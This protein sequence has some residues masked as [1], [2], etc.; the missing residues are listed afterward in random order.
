MPSSNA[1]LSTITR[2]MAWSQLADPS[3]LSA[4]LT[5]RRSLAGTQRSTRF[6]STSWSTVR[7]RVVQSMVE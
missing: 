5:L 6:C 1:R 7:V 3:S 4:R 2:L